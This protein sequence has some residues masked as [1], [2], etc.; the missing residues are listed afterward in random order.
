MTDYTYLKIGSDNVELTDLAGD[1]S[2][3][4]N[5]Y[6]EGGS[7]T[8]DTATGGGGGDCNVAGGSLTIQTDIDIIKTVVFTK[9]VEQLNSN[10]GLSTSSNIETSYD[11][12]P[13]GNGDL[14]LFGG[15]NDN[16]TFNGTDEEIAAGIS[17]PS[18]Q[19]IYFNSRTSGI[20][21]STN[22][23]T[24]GNGSASSQ[25]HTMNRLNRIPNYTNGAR[26]NEDP[27]NTKTSKNKPG[28]KKYAIA[29]LLQYDN[30][31]ENDNQKGGSVMCWGHS[32]HIKNFP[33]DLHGVIK[34]VSN[35]KAFAALKHDGTVVTWGD[36]N[37]GG[38]IKAKVD[39]VYDNAT[40]PQK[41]FTVQPGSSTDSGW[42]EGYTSG[43][44][45]YNTVDW[46]NS[47]VKDIVATDSAF[48]ALHEDGSV[49]C[50]GDGFGVWKQANN[51]YRPNGVWWADKRKN[52]ACH[53]N[54][55]LWW[56]YQRFP[57]TDNEN[58]NDG[59]SS[60]NKNVADPYIWNSCRFHVSGSDFD[61]Q[62]V[63]ASWLGFKKVEKIVT[64]SN[65]F[66][67]ITEDKKVICWHTPKYWSN[68]DPTSG[69]KWRTGRDEL[70]TFPPPEILQQV[71]MRA[72]NS[73]DPREESTVFFNQNFQVKDVISNK[74]GFLALCT[75]NEPNQFSYTTK[76]DGT[77]TH[78]MW[79]PVA[80]NAGLF[81]FVWGGYR[82]SP[83]GGVKHETELSYDNTYTGGSPYRY[84]RRGPEGN[85][86][87]E[88]FSQTKNQSKQIDWRPDYYADDEELGPGCNPHDGTTYWG[89]DGNANKAYN[90]PYTGA[91]RYIPYLSK[92]YHPTI[93][94]D[95]YDHKQEKFL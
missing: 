82:G 72:K 55:Y 75:I 61:V 18:S 34:I 95:L 67:A 50:W 65:S 54:K 77:A 28:P 48:A 42:V 21:E 29:I 41:T 66:C 46:S 37:F 20:Q 89:D 81:T 23:W 90:Q 44:R 43:D 10:E 11:S 14:D 6:L 52:L 58:D 15:D 94:A 78:H 45:V 30:T 74:Y 85:S 71:K 19:S 13:S 60:P 16:N 76:I 57:Y 86:A 80:D 56:K 31:S 26:E 4:V 91:W 7:H 92:T 53:D 22:S 35:N 87:G 36:E 88:T 63:N 49:F 12:I 73:E 39:N 32:E 40:P 83:D 3:L 93:K 25:T 51:T 59:W 33:K 84:D 68:S 38:K 9:P 70:S 27:S 1:I 17:I 79:T 8:L 47:N 24:I 2:K 62:I 69:G 5:E 64:S